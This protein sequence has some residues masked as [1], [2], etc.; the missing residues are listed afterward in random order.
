MSRSLSGLASEFSTLGKEISGTVK[1]SFDELRK[2]IQA[3]NKESKDLSKSMSGINTFMSKQ[4]TGL[5]DMIMNTISVALGSAVGA[6]A[7][8]IASIMPMDQI[9]A[10]LGE[11]KKTLIDQLEPLKDPLINMLKPVGEFLSNSLSSAI[12]MVKRF[13]DAISNIMSVLSNYKSELQLVAM[14]LAIFVAGLTTY[15]IVTNLAAICTKINT[16]ATGAYTAVIGVA[17]GVIAVFNFLMGF[18]GS[19]IGIVTLAIMGI[20]VIGYLLIQNW[21]TISQA[22]VTIWNS[23]CEFL[24][25]IWENI[26]NFAMSI[27]NGISTFLLTIWGS[28][29]SIAIGIWSSISAFIISIFTNISAF[30]STC[31]GGI[32]NVIVTAGVAIGAA[33]SNVF[34]GIAITISSIM[35]MAKNIVSNAFNAIKNIFS[36]VLRPNIKIP[37]INISGKFSLSPLQVPKFGISW[38]KTGGI[39]TGPS[40]IGLGENGDEAVLPLSNKRRMKPFANAVASM[41]GVDNKQAYQGVTIHIDSMSVRN[42]MDIK[43]IAE[44]L[45]RLTVRENRKLGLV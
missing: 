6:A 18:L 34:N 2:S 31:W 8:F 10:K 39:F 19:T 9:T 23:I 21:D 4:A 42:D 38:Y 24:I 7:G 12:D 29:S 37:Y 5:K 20:V 28:I 15:V 36:A 32:Q 44:E 30:I 27:W 26:S 40:I 41:I 3:V 43:K 17:N 45:N 1:V 11:L 13:G 35:D 25:G 14:L 22:A 33:V 16:I